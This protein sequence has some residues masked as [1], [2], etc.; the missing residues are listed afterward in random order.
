MIYLFYLKGDSF[1]VFPTCFFII[2]YRIKGTCQN[3]FNTL[4]IVLVSNIAAARLRG[5]PVKLG[6]TKGDIH[7]SLADSYA[8]LHIY[9]T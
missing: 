1:K 5:P 4:K 8:V 7:L 6:F 3:V 9:E 2:I